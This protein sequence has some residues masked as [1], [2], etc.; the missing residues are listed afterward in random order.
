M[1]EFCKYFSSLTPSHTPFNNKSTKI[2]IQ[3]TYK[4][5]SAN[6]TALSIMQDMPC[7]YI[8]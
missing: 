7:T 6:L 1:K 3:A 8:Q 2:Q 4:T 5:P